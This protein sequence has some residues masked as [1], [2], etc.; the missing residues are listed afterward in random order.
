MLL[1]SIGQCIYDGIN[2]K[3]KTTVI[4]NQKMV[5]RSKESIRDYFKESYKKREKEK[6]SYALGNLHKGALIYIS[7]FNTK[8]KESTLMAIWNI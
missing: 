1:Y 2:A 6:V 5:A 8:Q 3:S 4:S 7:L